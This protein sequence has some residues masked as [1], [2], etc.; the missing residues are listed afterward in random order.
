MKILLVDSAKLKYSPYIS[1]YTENLD[2]VNN[3]VHLLYWNRDLKSEDTSRF[4]G[5]VLHEFQRFQEDDVPK[6]KKVINFIRFR[7]YVKRVLKEHQFDFV[8]VF[9][10][11]PMLSDLLVRKFK[12]RYI[13][14]Y[15]DSTYERFAP[16][17]R[18]IA[19]LVNSSFATFTSSDGFRKYLPEVGKLYTSHNILIDSLNHRQERELKERAPQKIRVAFWG[20]IRNEELNRKIIERIASDNRFELH[21]YGREQETALNLK[22]FASELGAKNIFFHGEYQPQDRYE[23]VKSADIIH[24]I[25]NDSNMM[26]AMSNKYYDGCIFYLPQICMEGSFMGNSVERYGIGW[27]VNPYDADFTEKLYQKYQDL[28]RDAF[29][30]RCD[31]RL[32]TVLQEY[33]SGQEIIKNL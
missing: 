23:F 15:R 8:I 33:Q 16:F 5:I 24:N 6:L 7:K 18:I 17:R 28:D 20:M 2:K 21:Y 10:P 27:A 25:Y 4:E 29:F 3:E 14:D 12:E 9:S 32:A 26:L 13:Y 22:K 11:A 1:F 31:D 30:R 19:R